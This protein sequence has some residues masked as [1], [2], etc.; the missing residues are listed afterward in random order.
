MKPALAL[1]ASACAL[2]NADDLHFDELGYPFKNRKLEIIWKTTTNRVPS[3]M[4]IYRTVP[5]KFSL[6]LVTN[7]IAMGGF[8]DPDKVKNA[9]TPALKGEEAVYEEIP[10]HKTISLSPARGLAL[11]FNTSRYA[12]PREPDHGVPT[13]EQAPIL[14]LEAAKLLGIKTSDIARTLDSDQ[15]LFRRDKRT[16]SG[17]LNGK[18]TKRDTARGIYLYRAID[19]VPV[20][21]NGN[22][23]GLYVNFA[24]HAQMAQVELSWRNLEVKKRCSTAS[25]EEIARRLRNGKAYILANE[26]DLEKIAKIT[27]LEMVAHYRTFSGHDAQGLVLPIVVIQANAELGDQAVPV[28]FV[29]PVIVD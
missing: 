15:F 3:T 12:Q 26:A 16:M 19:G 1:L 25:R 14:A 11:F 18:Y 23:G 8:K 20:Y 27:I 4:N 17:L 7:L 9:L 29:C 2:A 22:C 10:A 21:G 13:D 6:S 24:N 5:S 28:Q